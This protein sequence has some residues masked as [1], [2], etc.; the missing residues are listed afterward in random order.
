VQGSSCVTT[1]DC[2]TGLG[3]DGTSN[4]CVQS[5]LLT[6]QKAEAEQTGDADSSEDGGD[7]DII[8]AMGPALLVVLGLLV[9]G[10]VALV[11]FGLR[12]RSRNSAS[13]GTTAHA[14]GMGGGGGGYGAAGE[15]TSRRSRSSYRRSHGFNA[16]SPPSTQGSY[17]SPPP[18][19][20]FAR[21]APPPPP[22]PP[23]FY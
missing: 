22:P 8:D 16:H 18:P 11:F 19:P 12:R 4:I 21:S 17:N 23:G 2:G 13:L 5:S 1:A 20:P 3:C 10:I 9:L 7:S 15:R 6:G 14:Y